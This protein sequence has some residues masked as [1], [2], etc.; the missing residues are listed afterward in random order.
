MM[1]REGCI[2]ILSSE[3]GMDWEKGD[4]VVLWRA[5]FVVQYVQAS[6]IS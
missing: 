6:L 3:G 4:F 1:V 2:H 5:L